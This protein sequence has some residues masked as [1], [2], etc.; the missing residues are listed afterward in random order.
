MHATSSYEIGGN[1]VAKIAIVT[2]LHA[3][4]ALALLSMRIAAPS[5]DGEAAII[6]LDPAPKVIPP[7]LEPV[8]A[9]A[10]HAVPQ[11]YVPTTVID[12][13]PTEAPI[14]TTTP[15]KPT[16]SVVFN[17]G[18]HETF[19]RV[20]AIPAKPVEKQVFRAAQSGNCAVPNYP[21][22]SARNG[23][24]GTV[25]LALLIAADGHVADAKVT[26][27]SG[28]RELDRAAVAALSLCT[29]KPATSNGVP[30]S[31]WGKIAYV[32]TLDQ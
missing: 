8:E 18:E 14:L 6:I 9:P 24:S 4:A 29:F 32:W 27:T 31:A 15:I 21:A 25:G 11:I 16:A 3:G 7:V 17:E 22:A 26:S 28:F 10:P 20:P 1:K 5:H 2:L 12:T 23:D 13:F 30:E 19:E